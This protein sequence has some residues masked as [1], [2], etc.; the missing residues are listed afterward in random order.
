M[1]RRTEDR[2]CCNEVQWHCSDSAHAQGWE[3]A[4]DSAGTWG[5]SRK[6]QDQAVRDQAV[7]MLEPWRPKRGSGKEEAAGTSRIRYWGSTFLGMS[8]SD[9]S[10]PPPLCQTCHPC[11][12]CLLL[13]SVSLRS[14]L[15]LFSTTFTCWWLSPPSPMGLFPRGS[16]RGHAVSSSGVIPPAASDHLGSETPALLTPYMVSGFNL[17]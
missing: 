3:C 15:K 8:L 13:A 17:C 5:K 16:P 7:G 11:S 9:L 1:V 14:W 12:F 6:R 10:H 4:G 2:R